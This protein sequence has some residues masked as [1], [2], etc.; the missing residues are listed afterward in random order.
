[1]VHANYTL[2]LPPGSGSFA[3]STNGLAS[4]NHMLE[5]LSH[6]ICE[7]VERDATSVWYQWG[8]T[9][10]DRTRVDL[11]TITHECCREALNKLEQ[12]GMAVA[13]WDTTTD[14]AVPSFYCMVLDKVSSDA[15]P[16]EGA[17]CHPASHIALVR[18]LT[19]AAQVRA[20]YIMGSRDD[21]SR[22]E[23]HASAI[24]EK[25]HNAW[26]LMDCEAPMRDFR[27]VPSHE[28][29]SFEDD[30][31]WT[32]ERLQA[33]GV[34]QVIAVDLTKPEFGLP[35][36]RVVVPGLESPHDDPRYV[37]GVRARAARRQQS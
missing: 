34:E 36:V 21:L 3:A 23:Y 17:G 11:S 22:D 16:G 29:D 32:L 35:V 8:R 31:C 12:A 5:A 26:T 25:L 24:G 6:G 19:E 14:V 1:M 13:V 10:R 18:A 37:A 33:S 20:T 9:A 7:V 4:G 30:L 2:A 15:H 28:F 27:E